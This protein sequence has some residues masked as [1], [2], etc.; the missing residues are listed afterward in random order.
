MQEA[1]ENER[2]RADTKRIGFKETDDDDAAVVLTY[3]LCYCLLQ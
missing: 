2:N 1:T 3:A